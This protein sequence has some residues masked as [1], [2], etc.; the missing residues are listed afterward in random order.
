MIYLLV[1]FIAVVMHVQPVLVNEQV[2]RF[3][4][5]YWEIF[6]YWKNVLL[7]ICTASVL[8]K[9]ITHVA[10]KRIR[11]NMLWIPPF[12]YFVQVYISCFLSEYPSLAWNGYY[13]YREGGYSILCYPILMIGAMSFCDFKKITTSLKI[14]VFCVGLVGI[15]HYCFGNVFGFP[16]FK[17]L[18]LGFNSPIKISA[19]GRPIY[20]T[21][22]NANH[23][24]LYCSLLLPF[25]LVLRKYVFVCILLFLT[26]ASESRAAWLSVFFTCIWFVPWNKKT[27]SIL[28]FLI[29]IFHNQIISKFSNWKTDLSFQD[30]SLSG[31]VYMWKN[32]M[33]MIFNMD[34]VLIGKGSSTYPLY[35]NQYDSDGKKRA[36]WLSPT[37]Y[38]DRPHNMYLQ[39]VHASGWIALYWFLV[40]N[41]IFLYSAFFIGDKYVYA[42][43][44]AVVGFLICGFFTDSMVGVSPIYWVLIGLGYRCLENTNKTQLS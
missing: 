36:G 17:Q 37:I 7:F 43:A 29:A 26:V 2:T 21:L 4:I 28:V 9:L 5:T 14:S 16:V 13:N 19:G 30:S 23:L 35:F 34:Q 32:T 41:A 40:M 8:L 44:F 20:S 10:S 38:I 27:V 22:M 42:I 24:A 39:M 31:R 6:T 18:I 15:L 12:I 3:Y 33:P 1:A 25:F 11:M